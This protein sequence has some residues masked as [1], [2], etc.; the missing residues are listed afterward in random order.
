MKKIILLLSFA[1]LFITTLPVEA[2]TAPTWKPT[3]P[4]GYTP[5]NWAKA[6]GIA[7]FMKA[8]T[9]NGYTDFLTV[10]YLPYNQ[11][12]FISSSTPPVA[13]GPAQPPF[14]SLET[15][16]TNADS[17]SSVTTVSNSEIKNDTIQ[18]WAVPRIV[19]EETKI[20]HP[21]VQFFWNVPFFNITVPTTDLSLGLKTTT[22]SGTTFMTSGSRPHTDIAQDRR[23]LIINNITAS[24]RI[25][26][27]DET[28]FASTT[29]GDQAVEG[30]SP[31][32][33]K[34][35][36][37]GAA[38]ARLF[39][40]TKPNGK[41]LIIY[42]S[43]DA[44]PQ[45]ASDALLAAGVPLENQLQADGGASATC[46]YNLP[47]QYF[48][49]PGRTLPYLMG[50]TPILYRA[51]ITT[52]NTKVRS[53]AGTKFSNIRSLAKGTPVTIFQEKNGWVRIN[54]R[55]EWV[56]ATYVKKI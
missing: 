38:T 49:E 40:G 3:T 26:D 35:D 27:F 22:A 46:A 33:L 28:I 2:K 17:S 55:E 54:S 53:G 24:G 18:D 52:K 37:A 12:Q 43:R 51:T 21:D 36:G 14:N 42:C 31:L 9:G 47:G 44:S 5:I 56:L 19:T 13:W 1:F 30:F 29:I 45:E 25:S 10:I 48:V 23:M 6:R 39:I 7:S 8:P 20:V 4:D 41:E 15:T 34:T 50:A 11:V 16:T 32:T